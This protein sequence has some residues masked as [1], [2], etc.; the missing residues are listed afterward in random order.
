MYNLVHTTPAPLLTDIAIDDGYLS[1]TPDE[2]IA[3]RDQTIEIV[4]ESLGA[5]QKA[6][7][8]PHPNPAIQIFWDLGTE[9][10]SRGVPGE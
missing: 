4:R 7:L 6:K 5:E 1:Y 3:Y 9:F 2:I 8:N 10:R